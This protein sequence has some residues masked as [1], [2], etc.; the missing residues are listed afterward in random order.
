MRL[1]HVALNVVVF[2]FLSVHLEKLPLSE[3]F[4]HLQLAERVYLQP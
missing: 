4:V 2:Y 1:R 3:Q